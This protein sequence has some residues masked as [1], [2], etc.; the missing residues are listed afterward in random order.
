MESLQKAQEL[1]G[2]TPKAKAGFIELADII[3][4]FRAQL[5]ELTPA[6]LID[7]LIRRLDYL[8]WLADG[9][10]QGE[11]RI[12]NV[13]ELL[14]VAGEYQDVGLAGFLE[15]VSLI[16]DIDSA[17]LGS[18]AVI[19]MTLHSAKGL[20]F[21][22]V[23][24][25]GLEEGVL[26][27]SRALYD[28]SEMEEERRLMYVGMTR[29]KDELYLTYAT[30]RTLYGSRLHNPPSRFLSDIEDLAAASLPFVDS[31]EPL[32]DDAPRYVP[33]LAEGDGVKH[34]V[35]GEGTVIE[36]TG[37]TAVIY[38]KGK[39]TKKLNIAF[40]PLTKIE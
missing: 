23:Y 34:Q 37:E 20:E 4:S 25:T 22:V 5:E 6:N 8:R 31:A 29:A 36:L 17:D 14:S 13:K 27:H 2:L 39:G 11:A 35:F 30:G 21:P 24:I 19:L 38:F 1:E 33:E 9:T 28:A 26:P 40:A 18:D 12:E 10:P 15:E 7:S 16:S 3:T 32:E